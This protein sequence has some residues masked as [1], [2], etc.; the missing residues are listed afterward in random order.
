MAISSRRILLARQALALQT[1]FANDI[2][3]E[4]NPTKPHQG[5]LLTCQKLLADYPSAQVRTLGPSYGYNCHGLTFASRRTQVS[6]SSEVQHIL[7]EDG[8]D[9]VSIDNALPGD[10]VIYRA[11]ETGEFEHSGIVVER[12]RD[13]SGPK[14]VSKWG[15]S[16][17]FVHYYMACPYAPA[18]VT[19]HRMQK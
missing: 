6:S 10:I 1:R 2:A 14:V 3:N 7:T 4:F 12:K 17:E 9:I 15:A 19:F 11:P 13:L 8:Y 5:D 16:Q 18:D